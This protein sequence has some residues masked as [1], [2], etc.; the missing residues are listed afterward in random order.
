MKGG[1][2]FLVCDAKIIF[3]GS[4]DGPPVHVR[5]EAMFVSSVGGVFVYNLTSSLLA[6]IRL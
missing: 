6:N 5:A 4:G 1:G 2:R 3:R